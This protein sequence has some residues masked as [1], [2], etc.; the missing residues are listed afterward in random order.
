MASHHKHRCYAVNQLE[1]E[2]V[3]SAGN[4][5]SVESAGKHAACG[6]ITFLLKE[7]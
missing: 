3:T 5:Q 2:I 6:K 4:M 7:T 1:C